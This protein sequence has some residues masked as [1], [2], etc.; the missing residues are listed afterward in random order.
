M[1][2]EL[3]KERCR[4]MEKLGRMI[5][6]RRIVLPDMSPSGFIIDS[7]ILKALQADL[8]IWNNFLNFPPLYQRARID[9]I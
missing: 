7:D 6:T 5:D 2:S 9:I 8:T 3:N 4:R 1:V